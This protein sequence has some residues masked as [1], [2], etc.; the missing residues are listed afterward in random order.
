[1][2]IVGAVESGIALWY[3]TNGHWLTGIFYVVAVAFLVFVYLHREKQLKRRDGGRR[4]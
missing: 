4:Y 3:L 2:G 1:L